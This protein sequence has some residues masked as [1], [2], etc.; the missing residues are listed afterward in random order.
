MATLT[1]S[2]HHQAY[3]L[4]LVIA[5]KTD[6]IIES[7]LPRRCMVVS[8]SLFFAGLAIPILMAVGVLPVNLLLGLLGLGLAAT[9]G[10]L[11]LILCGEI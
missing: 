2:Y 1:H 5:K 9:G 11:A 10:T 7:L 6:S 3:P 8:A 4:K